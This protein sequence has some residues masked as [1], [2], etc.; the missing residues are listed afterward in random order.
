MFDN[1]QV[2]PFNGGVV[3]LLV[4]AA[5]MTVLLQQPVS[6]TLL[7]S[8]W[9]VSVPSSAA[10][11]APLLSHQGSTL[12]HLGDI[13]GDSQPELLV[14]V[15][16]PPSVTAFSI[17]P[18]AGTSAAAR[19]EASTGGLIASGHWTASGQWQVIVLH[20]T[21]LASGIG[22]GKGRRPVAMAVSGSSHAGM[23][24]TGSFTPGSAAVLIAVVTE[25]Y[26]VVC[27]D[28]ELSVVWQSTAHHPA[29]DPEGLLSSSLVF[30]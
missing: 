10:P 3:G 26:S 21:S 25:D 23:A 12:M 29:I 5:V 30:R 2:V 14:A 11:L 16:D 18:N 19:V 7:E 13:T 6:V 28:G 17:T 27:L 20:T 24:A 9:R 22:S 1:E 4:A 8:A 15:R